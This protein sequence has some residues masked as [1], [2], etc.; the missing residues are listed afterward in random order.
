MALYDEAFCRMW[1]FY[2]AGSEASFR[3]GAMVVYQLQL[4]H[5]VDVVPITRNYIG[6][7]EDRLAG[8]EASRGIPGPA[9]PDDA[10]PGPQ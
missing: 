10:P 7:E 6:A 9:W 3:E 4:A 8:L 1:E 5:R 2:L